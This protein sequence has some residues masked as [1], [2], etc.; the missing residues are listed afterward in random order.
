EFVQF[1]PTALHGTPAG[2][3]PLL[4]EALR[5]EGALLRDQVGSRFVDEMQPRD[6]VAA[7]VAARMR[8]TGA[9]HLWLDV[10]GV[11]GFERRFPSLAQSAQDLGLDPPRDWLPVAPAAHYVCGGVVTD[12]DGATALPGLWAAGEVA[13]TGVHGA[14][15]LAS[16]SLLE[17]MVFGARVV[18]A[19]L[20]GQDTPSASG[21]LGPVLWPGAG[22]PSG[23]RAQRLPSRSAGPGRGE[24]HPASAG[25]GGGEVVEP[26]GAGDRGGREALQHAMTRGAGVVRTADSLAEAAKVVAGIAAAGVPPGELSNLLLVAEAVVAAA[27]AREESRGGHRREDYPAT[28]PVFSH[29]FVQ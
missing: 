18:E 10:S 13:C 27:T 25:R 1:H 11:E 2:P 19:V 3:R 20:S 17:G 8:M 23:I 9:E 7:A 16:N 4:S 5:G 21:A 29:R 15:R 26:A 24:P 12:L 14:N 22:E 28:S 6:V